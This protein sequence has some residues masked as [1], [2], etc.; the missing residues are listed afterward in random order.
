MIEEHQRRLSDAPLH[1]TKDTTSIEYR[2]VINTLRPDLDLT[3][4]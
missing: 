2:D 1:I 3:S 4:T